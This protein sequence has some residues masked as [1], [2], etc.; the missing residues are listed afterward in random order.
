[1]TIGPGTFGPDPFPDTPSFS[2]YSSWNSRMRRTSSDVSVAATSSGTWATTQSWASSRSKIAGGG[3]LAMRP[4]SRM[5]NHA[6]TATTTAMTRTPATICTGGALRSDAD[7]LRQQLPVVGGIAEQDLRALRPLEVEVGVVLP[8]EADAAVDL[9]VLGGG[10]EVRVGAVR[11]GEARDD[12][13]LLVVLGCCPGRVV[14]RRLRRLDL[15]QHGGALVLDGLERADGATELHAHLRVLDRHLEHLLRA[16]D[17]L[18]RQTHGR[19]VERLRRGSPSCAGLAQRS[20]GDV[21]E[22]ETRLLPGLV[23]R[24]QRRAREAG[25]VTVDGE[26]R[27]AV[28]AAGT[29]EPRDGDERVR[30]VPVDHEHLRTRQLV[31][32]AA[33]AG[34]HGDPRRVPPAVRLGERER[35]DRLARR[36]AREQLALLSIGARVH[37]RVR[38]Q[39][40]RREVRRAQPDAPPPLEHDAELDEREAL[41]AVGFGDVQ[42]LEPELL[43][44]LLPHRL[45]VALGRL[46]EASY[47][48]RRRLRLHESADGLAELLLLLREREVHVSPSG[49]RLTREPEH[50][51]ADDVALDLAR[52]GVDR[53]GPAHHERALQL[54]ERVFT[55][56]LAL[57][58]QPV[59]AE[60]VHRDLP[61]P[62]VPRA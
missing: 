11:L 4:A 24:R 1:M 36:D 47:L 55:A 39:H 44:H 25:R 51:L 15:E 29:G 60:H 21:G 8:G 28:L 32:F 19:L 35:G 53:L 38:R 23:H 62:S 37:D 33:P 50:P 42:A 56:G 34:L 48:R 2:K 5:T 57:D 26:E 14:R 45:V 54:V 27:D 58:E 20:G 52:A 9:D 40:D 30:G 16:A 41:T 3:S 22:V 17:H 49:S 6:A 46:H 18:V 7:A 43:R 61:E 13:Q 59:R 10:V 12:R 31:V